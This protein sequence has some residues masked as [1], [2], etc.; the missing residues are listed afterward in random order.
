MIV[1][2]NIDQVIKD[3]IEDL[4]SINGDERDRIKDMCI[5]YYQYHNTKKYIGDYFSGTLQ[6]EIPLYTVNMT[7]R[8]VD[9]ISLCYKD[10][11]V[12]SADDE[13]YSEFTEDKDFTLK[14]VERIHN[15]LGTIALQVSWRDNKL[16]YIPRFNFE[17]VF[18]PDDPMNPIGIV[19]PAQ[20][21]TDSMYQTQEDEFIYWD[22]DRHFRFDINGNVIHINEEDV[23]P[24]GVLPFV[25]IQPNHQIDEFMNDGN[26]QDICNANRQIDIAMTMLQ[27][28]IRKA[29]GQYVIEGQVEANNIELGLNKVVVLDNG[30]MKNINPNVSIQNILDGIKFQ[31]QHVAINHHVSFDFG[32]SGSKSGVALKIENVELLEKREDDVEKF[33]RME[34]NLFELEKVIIEVETGSSVNVDFSIDYT[35]IKFPD[36]ERDMAEWDWKFQ[37]GLAD[38]V[39]YLMFHDPDGFPTR[40]S[41]EE[42]LAIRRKTSF[43]IKEN[44]T[45][46]NNILGIGNGSR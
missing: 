11:P 7:R 17:P 5:D 15:L 32:L 25:F 23:N 3:S 45:S 1:F 14:R 4:K 37:H 30:N 2:N 19:Y 12:R 44:G 35:E 29:G 46:E 26:A 31:L 42:Y 16:V 9:R 43:T 34:K 41:A 24:Y 13:K 22:S 28:H 38:K 27:H 10:A 8:L 6:T 18:N 20:K 33:R 36:P 21:T 39:D 40:E